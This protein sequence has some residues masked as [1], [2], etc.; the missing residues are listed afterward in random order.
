MKMMEEIDRPKAP[1]QSE[2]ENKALT[3]VRTNKP[4]YFN[5]LKKTGKLKEYC[6]R[7]ATK[8]MSY[9]KTLIVNG[10]PEAEA[11]NTAIRHEILESKSN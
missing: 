5:D 8:A 6:Q 4:K 1:T 10:T 7:R 9:A 11:W 2:L 3:F